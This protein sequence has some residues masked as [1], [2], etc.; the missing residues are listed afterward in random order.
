MLWRQA[1]VHPRH[2]HLVVRD[3]YH[4][5]SPR[6]STLRLQ[7]GGLDHQSF[8]RAT[9]RT[10]LNAQENSAGPRPQS[11]AGPFVETK[12][13][14]SCPDAHR[15]RQPAGRTSA[16]DCFQHMEYGI[17]HGSNDRIKRDAHLTEV[18]L[19]AFCHDR[20]TPHQSGD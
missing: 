7:T 4:Q 14:A 2:L 13:S 16:N 1:R 6:T 9:T 15:C 3:R 5:R 18:P 10:S 19:R 20:R 11:I 8:R 17:G 12:T